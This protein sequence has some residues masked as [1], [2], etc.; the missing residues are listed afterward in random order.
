MITDFDVIIVGD[1]ISALSAAWHLIF[2]HGLPSNRIAMCKAPEPFGAENE[3]GIIFGGQFDN[4][5]RVAN[6][7]GESF[8]ADLW[9]FGDQ[10]FDA[11][12]RWAAQHHV[13][14][15]T[16]R[17]LRLGTTRHEVAEMKQATRLLE[18]GGFTTQMLHANEWSAQSGCRVG[19]LVLAVQDEGPRGGWI[20]PAGVRAKLCEGIGASCAKAEDGD[21]AAVV[22]ESRSHP[23]LWLKSGNSITAEIIIVA[24]HLATD[25]VVPPLEGALVAVA[26]Q[27]VH[28]STQ[29]PREGAWGNGSIMFSASHGYEWGVTLDDPTQYLAGGGRHLRQWAGIEAKHASF[30]DPSQQSVAQRLGTM[31]PWAHHPRVL[32]RNA[33]LDCRPCDELPLIGPL[34]ATSRVMVA[35]GYMGAGITMG[36]QAGRSLARLAAQGE[37]PE[38]PRRLW[39]ER[40][41]SLP[42]QG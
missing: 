32:E 19:E 41:R 15:M 1:G 27:W 11:T 8:A 34:S 12:T 31:F 16:R 35:T 26:D 42:D 22:D 33:F 38:L 4:Y 37:A 10:A 30:H 25:K 13:P 9:R 23:R 21:V 7:H 24:A 29:Q 40:L 2:E 14:S 17:R 18:R 3:H 28:Y 5:T 36:F 39:P 6:A 20:D